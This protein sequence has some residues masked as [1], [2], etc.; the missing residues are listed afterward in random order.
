[1]TTIAEQLEALALEIDC[2]EVC[3]HDV[4]TRIRTLLAAYRQSTTPAQAPAQAAEPAAIAPSDCG[5]TECKG[6]PRCEKC[7]AMAREP[8]ATGRV[9]SDADIQASCACGLTWDCKRD[10]NTRKC[11]FCA[12]MFAPTGSAAPTGEA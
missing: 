8:A 2:E 10:R 6:R 12:E 7:T 11:S 1:M 9:L 3:G 5:L 4:A